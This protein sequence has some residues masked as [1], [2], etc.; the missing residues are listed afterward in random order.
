MREGQNAFFMQMVDQR[1]NPDSSEGEESQPSLRLPTS[2]GMGLPE[3]QFRVFL[4]KGSRLPCE[5]SARFL[6]R[7]REYNKAKI[8]IFMGDAEMVDDNI[9]LGEIGLDNIRLNKDGQALLDIIFRADKNFMLYVQLK[10]EPGKKSSNITIRLPRDESAVPKGLPPHM[11]PSRAKTQQ[12]DTEILIQKLSMLEEKM[13]DMEKELEEHY[14][15]QT[16]DEKRKSASESGKKTEH[17][18]KESN[19]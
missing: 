17:T 13:Q 9:F 19:E 7:L 18:D 15:S 16:Q 3:G 12:V 8:K 1:R 11:A 14:K 5:A 4:P 10:D 2:I 6:T